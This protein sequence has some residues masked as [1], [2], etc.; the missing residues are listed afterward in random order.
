MWDNIT[1]GLYFL[2]LYL[3]IE[4]SLLFIMNLT[5]FYTL[6]NPLILVKFTLVWFFKAYL[7]F[8]NYTKLIL[9]LFCFVVN[10]IFSEFF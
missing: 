9:E 7:S 6:L 1:W 3:P 10:I 4:F 8:E 2:V 5:E